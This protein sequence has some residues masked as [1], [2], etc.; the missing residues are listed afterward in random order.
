MVRR[1]TRRRFLADASRAVLGVSGM[2]TAVW[3]QSAPSGARSG[4]PWVALVEDLDRQI[5]ALMSDAKLP[6]LSVALIREGQV[7]WRRAYGV[8]DA[9]ARIPV[10]YDTVFEA[11]SMSK[12]VFAYAVMKLRERGVLDLDVPLTKYTRARFLEGDSRLVAT[13]KNGLD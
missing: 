4:D 10:D 1:P 5:P 11:A 13:G 12:P 3:R 7:H 9:V 6:G 2:S 8:K